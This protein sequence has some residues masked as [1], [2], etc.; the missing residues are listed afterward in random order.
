[1]F[2]MCVSI[3]VLVYVQA[4]GRFDMSFSPLEQHLVSSP[5]KLM[6]VRLGE[7]AVQRRRS[8]TLRYNDTV[9]VLV[10]IAVEL[11]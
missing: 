2:V 1:M 9:L 8:E 10:C 6:S 5:V 11:V 3:A 7:D 4:G